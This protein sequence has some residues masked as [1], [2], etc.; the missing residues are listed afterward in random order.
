MPRR[1][2]DTGLLLDTAGVARHLGV[3]WHVAEKTVR[4][5]PKVR[6]PNVS[7]VYVKAAD[8]QRMIDEN[9]KAA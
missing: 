2:R 6:L 5:L 7:K 9:T 3:S 4:Q 1:S 8:L